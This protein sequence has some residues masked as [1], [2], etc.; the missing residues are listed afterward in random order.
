M[1]A[2]PIIVDGRNIFE[3]SKV[4]SFGFEYYPTGR[5]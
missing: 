1:M 2:N 5:K 3:P 4:K